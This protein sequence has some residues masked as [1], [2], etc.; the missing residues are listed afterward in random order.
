MAETRKGGTGQ[1]GA[2]YQEYCHLGRLRTGG[3]IKLYFYKGFL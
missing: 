1:V 3:E 2:I